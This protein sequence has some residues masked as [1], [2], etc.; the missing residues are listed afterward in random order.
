MAHTE[1][2]QFKSIAPNFISLSTH[3]SSP[4]AENQQQ[5]MSEQQTIRIKKCI[6]WCGCITAL[7]LLFVVIIIVLAFTV[8]NVKEPEVRMNGVTLISGNFSVNS[9]VND[10]VTILADISVKNT[11][12]FT[13]KYKAVRT[14]VYYN[15]VE[16]GGGL[17]PAGKSKARRT[18]RF[19]ATMEIIA[20]KL[21]NNPKWIIDLRDQALNISS[22]TK[23][24]GKV[25]IL[26]LFKRKV[27]VEL[28][29]TSQYNI[30][31]GLITHGDNC[32][33]YVNV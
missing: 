31:T 25:K 32:V 29:C 5:H 9:N 22:Y 23:M 10:N 33:G 27:G 2:E 1:R 15:G 19:N 11:N 6:R 28:N 21:V 3:F 17:T 4:S 18:S 30:T 24:D 26:N 13:F 8:Y 20:A 14:H 7:F 16:I 12:S